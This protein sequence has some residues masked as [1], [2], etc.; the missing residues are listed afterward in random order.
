MENGH[1]FRVIPNSI[2]TSLFKYRYEIREKV[3]GTLGISHEFVMGHVG[4]FAY[5][6]NQS[7]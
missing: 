6:K 2:D 4:R 1:Y 5:A 7:F 3:R